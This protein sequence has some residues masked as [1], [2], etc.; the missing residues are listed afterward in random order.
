MVAAWISAD[1]GVGPAIASGSQTCNGSCADLPQAPIKS[2]HAIQDKSPQCPNGSGGYLL[3]CA[4]TSLYCEVPTVAIAA[5]IA[6]AKPKWPMGL[7]MKALRE[8]LAASC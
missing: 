7:V 8:A 3:A 5:K 6:G 4:R 2:P 1:T